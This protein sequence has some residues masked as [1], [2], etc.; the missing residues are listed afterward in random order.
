MDLE[1]GRVHNIVDR[2]VAQLA[3]SLLL[4]LEDLGSY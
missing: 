1:K 2:V 3:D 4:I